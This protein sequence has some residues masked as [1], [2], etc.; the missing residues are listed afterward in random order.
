MKKLLTCVC[1]LFASVMAWA[2]TEPADNE[3]WVKVSEEPGDW[4]YF[5]TSI[6]DYNN[7]APEI[8]DAGYWVVKCNKSIT[9][10]NEYAFSMCSTL[11]AI[12]LPSTLTSIKSHAFYTCENLSQVK[13]AEGTLLT[14]IGEDAFE[15][16][17]GLTEIT[18]PATV[19]S[20]GNS[21]FSF[22]SGNADGCIHRNNHL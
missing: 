1:L 13:F 10:F 8:N 14:E 7:V 16:C 3:I 4:E 6:S 19:T 21:A 22:R 15:N 11:T 2:Q 5:L 17:E 9:Q 20:I 12:F 18:I